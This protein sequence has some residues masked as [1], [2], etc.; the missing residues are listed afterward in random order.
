MAVAGDGCVCR[1]VGELCLEDLQVGYWGVPLS[2]VHLLE[3]GLARAQEQVVQRKS[4]LGL[5]LV[6]TSHDL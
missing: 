3:W 1:Q 5:R 6:V 4:L 2:Q